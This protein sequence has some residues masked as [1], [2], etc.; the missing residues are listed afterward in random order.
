MA[1]YSAWA[2][3]LYQAASPVSPWYAALAFVALA[4]LKVLPFAWHVSEAHTMNGP[5]S[6]L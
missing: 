2:D 4:N 3:K 1:S 5:P 6:E